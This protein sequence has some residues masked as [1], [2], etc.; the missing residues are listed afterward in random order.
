MS[1]KRGR[2]R[3]LA[4]NVGTRYYIAFPAHRKPE[5]AAQ[6]ESSMAAAPPPKS[7]LSLSIGD[8][9]R[10]DATNEVEEDKCAFL[11]VALCLVSYASVYS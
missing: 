1:E 9:N 8:E 4:G 7:A 2:R 10:W 3:C 5:G 6:Q 11:V